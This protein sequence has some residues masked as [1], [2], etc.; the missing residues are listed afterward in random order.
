MSMLATIQ[1]ITHAE[2]TPIP[3]S[4]AVIVSIA[5]SA[6]P[7]GTGYGGNASLVIR[8]LTEV[9]TLLAALTDA[10]AILAQEVPVA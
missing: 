6:M 4:G 2:A 3:P 1:F 5:L 8:T 10:R 7:D 9:D